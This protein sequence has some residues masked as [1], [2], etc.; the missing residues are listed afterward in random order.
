M[1]TR[2]VGEQL[3][4]NKY[5]DAID[6]SRIPTEQDV[7][8]AFKKAIVK[9]HI[10]LKELGAGEA[11]QEGDTLKI[12]AESALPKFNKPGV[13]VT[14]GRGLYNKDLELALI[15]K[16]IGESVEIMVNDSPVKAT[17]LSIKRKVL[18]EPTDAMVEELGIE[19]VHTVEEYRPKFIE[20]FEMSTFGPII[21]EMIQKIMEDG[22]YEAPYDEDLDILGELEIGSFR[23]FFREEKGVDIDTATPEQFK[24]LLGVET[25]EAF[26]AERRDWYKIKVKQ[27]LSLLNV[28]HMQP[29]GEFDPTS[30]YE[31]LGDLTEKIWKTAKEELIRRK[32]NGSH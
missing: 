28:F 12:A 10:E 2:Y 29:E 14:V 16:K 22:K 31:V 27:C 25:A 7:E 30:R 26:K 23:N 21:G 19:G 24:E 4:L 8:E 5:I 9:G 1:K 11:V 13:T 3:D 15:G 17:V 32:N 20:Q 6:L 18:P